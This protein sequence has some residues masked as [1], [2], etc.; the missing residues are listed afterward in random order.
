[1]GLEHVL[2]RRVSSESDVLRARDRAHAARTGGWSYAVLYL[3]ETSPRSPERR[4]V[5]IHRDIAITQRL[6]PHSSE[7]ERDRG[8]I[9]IVVPCFNEAEVLTAFHDR[10]V[11]V[12]QSLPYSWSV[13]YVNDGSRDGTLGVM[14]AL[15]E[16]GENVSV[17]N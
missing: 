10:L 15:R 13:T 16:R 11:P 5:T 8:H 7:I 4:I 6:E 1:R 14:L 12:M 9:S 17:L 2:R 3:E